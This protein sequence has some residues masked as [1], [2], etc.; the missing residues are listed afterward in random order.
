MA[1]PNATIAILSIG[2]MGLGIARL[3]QAHNYRITT[4]SSGRSHTT[5]ARALSAGITLHAT[6]KELVADADYI[7]SIVPPR[8][9]IATAQRISAAVAALPQEKELWYLELNAISP[10]TLLKID[11]L[12][13]S[14]APS[15]RL[16]DGGI[17]GFPPT[18][19]Q[20]QVSTQTSSPLPSSYP[21]WK[22]PGIPLSGP[23][24]LALAPSG[25][26]L[27]DTLNTTH[28]SPSLGSASALKCCF[29]SL[30]KGFTAIALQ[31]YTTASSLDILAP[32]QS[33]L[34]AYNPGA[35][36]K[37]ETGMLGCTGKAGRWVEEMREIG[38]TFRVGGG[39]GGK[40]RVFG[41]VADVFEEVAGV[42]G[43][44]GE[45]SVERVLERLGRRL[46]EERVEEQE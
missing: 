14:N 45:G 31:S 46:R 12:F 44:E 38:E 7:F 29:A 37:A 11:E 28:I 16:I 2:Q 35:R 8:D 22:K 19:I 34:D 40:G 4:S 36:A 18:L 20:P 32:L 17:I 3:L 24:T 13:K 33:Y 41:E 25:A 23:H 42:G 30:S 6:D 27:A 39:W 26:H 10:T 9:A 5:Q 1:T 21:D 43:W 15:V